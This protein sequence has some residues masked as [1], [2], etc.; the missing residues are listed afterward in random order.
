MKV[1]KTCKSLI[2][3][4]L[5]LTMSVSL[6]IAFDAE[7]HQAEGQMRHLG[8]N[9]KSLSFIKFRFGRRRATVTSRVGHYYYYYYY[10]YYYTHS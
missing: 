3:M 8:S 4:E 10:Y 5:V 9:L 2:E 1:L 7:A 6:P